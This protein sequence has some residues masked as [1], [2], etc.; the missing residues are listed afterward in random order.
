MLGSKNHSAGFARFAMFFRLIKNFKDHVF[1]VNMLAV[2]LGAW[3]GHLARRAVRPGS[4]ADAC[5]PLHT[6]LPTSQLLHQRL[7]PKGAVSFLAN[8]N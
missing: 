8:L 4:R 5:R 2:A 7:S 6:S 3:R 1:R